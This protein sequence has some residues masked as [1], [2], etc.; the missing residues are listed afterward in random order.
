MTDYRAHALI[1]FEIVE[2]SDLPEH[3]MQAFA[4][5]QMWLEAAAIEDLLT[6]WREQAGP[7]APQ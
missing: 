7:E 3:K 4:V 5:A 6:H 2:K 1:L